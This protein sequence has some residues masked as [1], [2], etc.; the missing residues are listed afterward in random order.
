M[1]F[2]GGAA[3][4]GDGRMEIG[5]CCGAF[6]SDCCWCADGADGERRAGLRALAQVLTPPAHAAGDGDPD[7]IEL[8]RAAMDAGEK[9]I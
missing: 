9:K 8:F 5:E 6:E 1:I 3:R 7:D 4:T 2:R